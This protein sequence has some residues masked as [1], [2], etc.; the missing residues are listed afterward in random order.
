MLVALGEAYE[1]LDKLQEAKK[2]FWKAHSMADIE[3][4]ALIKLAKYVA[5]F[6]SLCCKD[7]FITHFISIFI[8]F[9]GCMSGYMKK[10]KQLLLMEIS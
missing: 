9:S 8:Y 1:K 5:F 3:G 7:D 10:N 2:C 4:I 6:S